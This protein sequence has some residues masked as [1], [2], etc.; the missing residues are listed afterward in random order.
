MPAA[1]DAIRQR[2]AVTHESGQ[3]LGP[4]EGQRAKR[5]RRI[6]LLVVRVSFGTGDDRFGDG[7]RVGG[8][9]S[10]LSH[11]PAEYSPISDA[12]RKRGGLGDQ[13]SSRVR[14]ETSASPASRQVQRSARARARWPMANS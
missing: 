9:W 2:V 14:A 13:D 1:A 4:W 8:Y 5:S 11:N 3:S 6:H 12:R 7:P 10:V